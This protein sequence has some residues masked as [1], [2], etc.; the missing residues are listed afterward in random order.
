[1]SIDFICLICDYTCFYNQKIA[2]FR[3]NLHVTE[4]DKIDKYR[5]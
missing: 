2:H 5:V 4:N 3:R 1:M